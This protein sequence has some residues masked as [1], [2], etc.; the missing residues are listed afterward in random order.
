MAAVLASGPGAVISH[1][2]AADA[3]QILPYAGAAIDVSIPSRSWR[4]LAGITLHRSLGLCAEDCT[5]CDD[6]PCTTPARTLLDLADIVPAWRLERA[7][8]AAERLGIYDHRAVIDVIKRAHGRPAA[9]RLSSV[10]AAYEAPPSTKTELERRALELFDRAGLPQPQ[11]NKLVETAD[12]PLEVDFLWP[13][14]KLVV[15]ADSFEWHRSRAAFEEDRRR[16]QLL[17]AAG[18]AVVRVTWRQLCDAPADVIA[19][20]A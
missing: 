9:Q 15:E 12:G 4:P 17:H 13:D 11:V 19:A 20:V 16:D 8:E 7:I 1:R 2:T 6:I 5:K 18:Y 10:L 14:R 3:L